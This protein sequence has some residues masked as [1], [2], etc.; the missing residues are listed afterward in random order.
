MHRLADRFPRHVLL[1]PVPVQGDG[2]ADKIAKAILDF[3]NMKETVNTPKPDVIIIA[4]GGGS[5]EDLMP[6]NEEN[7]IRAAA[8]SKIP[9]ISAVGHETDT[10]LTDFVA[11]LR[12]PT[13][14]GAAELCVPVRANL[15]TQTLDLETRLIKSSLRN[16]SEKKNK[17]EKLEA[18]LGDP[19]KL[20]ALKTQH[21][22][23][24][25]HKISNYFDK[26]LNNKMAKLKQ[27]S[28]QMRT[29]AHLIKE[30]SRRLLY[31]GQKLN[32]A[33]KGN[34]KDLSRIALVLF[35]KLEILSFK[36]VL[37]RGYAVIWD[38]KKKPVTTPETTRTGDN[39]QIEFKGNKKLEVIVHGKGK[40]PKKKL[41]EKDQG[42]LF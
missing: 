10:T 4:R 17:I 32:R 29:P 38:E 31:E 15:I 11:D 9:I 7:V 14:T 23:F 35:E 21:L 42:D 2:A 24:I 36:S 13:P 39:L 8:K 3:N 37:N 12:A 28:A 34:T 16:I 5:L 1:Y 6:F 18:K 30:E 25:S 20:L 22:D 41:K 26:T 19:G 33:I 40:K 27:T